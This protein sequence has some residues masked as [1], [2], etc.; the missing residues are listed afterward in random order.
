MKSE[1][2]NKNKAK[3]FAQYWN[4]EV[5]DHED[6]NGEGCIKVSGE[7][8][9]IC[10]DDYYLLLKPLSSIS[11]SEVI[12]LARIAGFDEKYIEPGFKPDFR[13]RFSELFKDEMVPMVIIDYLRSNGYATPWMGLSVEEMAKAGWIKISS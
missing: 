11:E 6:Y 13:E 7:M 8:I 4:Q 2:N 10:Y 1:I 5:I 3:F 12:D 9:R